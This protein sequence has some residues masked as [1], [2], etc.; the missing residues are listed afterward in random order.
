MSPDHLIGIDVGTGSA[1][2]GIFTRNGKMLGTASKPI[3]MW[4]PEGEL[5]EQSSTDIW[6]A[7]CA[8]VKLALK[9]AG[10][11]GS[12]VAGI[13]FDAACSMVAVDE[14]DRPVTVSPTGND[15]QNVIVWMDHRAIAEA[16][17]VTAQGHEVISYL[18]GTVSPEHQIPK[19]MWLKKHLPETWKRADR[20]YDLPDWLTYRATGRDVRSLCTTVCKWTYLGHEKSGS[21]WSK[22]F[23]QKIR[24][25]DGL[26]RGAF[27]EEIEP[28]GN[29]AG[30]LNYNSARELGLEV[31]TPVA[32][33]I[34]DA[35]SGGL[36]VLGMSSGKAS[37]KKG[38]AS[39]DDVLCLIG[40]TSSCHMAV[41]KKAR[42]VSGVW[43]P[44]Y[45][46]MVPGLWLNEGGQSATGALL[47]FVINTH[48]SHAEAV[49]Q[50]KADG[51]DIYTF[52][53]RQ[54]DDLAAK[55]KL[56][57]RC[58]LTKRYHVLPYFHGNRSPHA[59]P[60][61]RG[62]IH[63]LQLHATMED[64]ALQYYAVMQAIAYGTRDIIES[65]NAKGY[66]ITKLHACGGG[67]KN[68]LWLQEH[69]DA[70]G[71]D[72]LLPREPEAMLLGGA[73]LAAVG[74][75]IYADIPTA[76]SAMSAAGK[77]IKS[78]ARTA[79]YHAA[80]MKVHRELYADQKKYDGLM[81]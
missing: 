60:T 16:A 52:L 51:V 35:H 22:D 9:Q 66:K 13:A 30:G 33:G 63:G 70:T 1:R 2:A 24:L 54:V 18:G 81:G 55:L 31:G 64:Y 27:G 56:K 43:G 36:G 4:R 80:K 6:K 68:A 47:D 77:V 72:I 26:K 59:D 78:T 76:M 39:Y 74:A 20:Y 25:S 50:A 5:V 23:F 48:P 37:K 46:A 40:G 28:M 10:I 12:T 17:R 75:G 79:R 69:A 67:T 8:A 71:C 44:Y 42:F 38:A 65:M 57:H 32:V 19:L 15:E 45:S 3:Q 14:N 41:S 11:N 73:M 49:K 53:N 62:A 34:I 58:E 7:V 61:A 21:G 29:C